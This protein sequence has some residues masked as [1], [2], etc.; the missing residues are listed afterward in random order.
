MITKVGYNVKA[1]GNVN[2][3]IH[4]A[5]DDGSIHKSDYADAPRPEFYTALQSLCPYI[6]AQVL[7]IEPSYPMQ[8]PTAVRAVNFKAKDDVTLVT[9]TL[10]SEL[11]E[12][13]E[14]TITT[15]QFCLE[16]QNEQFAEVLLN[17]RTEAEVYLG[18]ERA[19]MSLA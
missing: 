11:S 19:Q 13:V 10:K 4:T 16:T 9:C 3:T 12:G 17:V 18:G 2:V 15:P 14:W 6:F 8:N 5:D 7:G 1:D